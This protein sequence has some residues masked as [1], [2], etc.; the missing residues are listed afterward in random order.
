MSQFSRRSFLAGSGAAI[1][2]AGIPRT[3]RAFSGQAPQVA[4][5]KSQFKIAVITDE[6]S[7]DFDHAC[8]VASQEFGMQWVELRGMWNKNILALDAS[9]IAKARQILSKYQLRVT[10]IASPLFKV[11]WPGAPLSKFSPKRDQFKADFTFKDQDD[12]L[13]KSVELAKAFA[14]NRVRGFDF[15]RLEDQ[16]PYRKE[17]NAKLAEAAAKL[18]TQ[19]ITFLLENEM[20]CNTATGAEAAKVLAAI[21]D[22]NLMLNWDPGN[23]AALGETPFPNGYDLLP[24]KRIGHCHCKD[25]IVKPGGYD[26]APVGKGVINWVGQ[27]EA[28]KKIGYNYAVSLETHWHG[29]SSPEESTRQSWAGMQADLKAAGALA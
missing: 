16:A 20:A 28:L 18:K 24:S 12:V 2:A 1:A 14:T 3:L 22:T 29:A 17:I 6:I 23:A 26:W 15:W 27:F 5:L 9:E 11:D 13:Q 19:G 21:P 4:R 8:A 25:T 10:D 7:Q